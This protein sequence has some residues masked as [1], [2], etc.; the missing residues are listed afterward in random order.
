[1]NKLSALT[2]VV[3]WSF[4]GVFG[5]LALTAHQTDTTQ[6]HIAMVLA[7]LGFL[8]GMS[9]WLRLARETR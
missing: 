4:F 1:M 8:V 9:S 6:V 5:Y 7:M 3:A 2:C